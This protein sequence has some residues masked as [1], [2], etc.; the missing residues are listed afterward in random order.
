M[1][2]ATIKINTIFKSAMDSV[3]R[4][5]ESR[6]VFKVREMTKQVVLKASEYAGKAYRF[7]KPYL[8]NT[9]LA[10]AFTVVA[11]TFTSGPFAAALVGAGLYAAV[12]G[13]YAYLKTGASVKEA[14]VVAGIAYLNG[15]GYGLVG[16]YSVAYVG[17]FTLNAV[18]FTFDTLWNAAVYVWAY[19]SYFVMA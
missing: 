17:L 9:A 11:G 3:K 7:V 18:G 6:L 10:T 16:A 5:T 15:F 13:T 12:K 1:T 14:L 2:T 8:F 19:A 4:V